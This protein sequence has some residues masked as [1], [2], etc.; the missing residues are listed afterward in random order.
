MNRPRSP[1][2]VDK[3]ALPLDTA[4]EKTRPTRGERRLPLKTK[5]RIRSPRVAAVLGRRIEGRPRAAAILAFAAFLHCSPVAAT[6]SDVTVAAGLNYEHGYQEPL[7]G[8]DG[9]FNE[10]RHTAGGVAAGDYDND[11]WIDLYAVR[12]DTGP[13]VLFRNQ[14]DGT[15]VEVGAAAGVAV[16]GT[17]GSGPIFAD[18]DG[19][20]WLD[21]LVGGVQ[22]AGVRGFR[23][24]GDGSFAGVDFG[25]SLPQPAPSSFRRGSGSGEEMPPG[26]RDTYSAAFGDYDRDGDLDMALAHWNVLVEQGES[27]ETL[28]R[29]DGD[30]HF[31]DVSVDS[32][33]AAILRGTAN[34]FFDFTFTPNFADVD[35]DGFPDLLLAADFGTSKVLRNQGD[36]TFADVTDTRVV[37]DENGMGAAIGD[38]DNDGDLDW[39][40][41]SIWDP[42][43]VAEEHWG[44]TGNRLYRN[45]GDGTFEDVTTAAGVRQGYWGWGATWADVNND[46]FL[47]LFHVNGWGRS[48]EYVP[49]R[50][51]YRDPSPLFV[52]A[53]DGTF[54][55]QAHDLGIDDT[56]MGRGVVSFDYDRDGDLDFFIANSQGRPRLWR[57]DGG[58]EQ[59][60]LTVKLRGPV[61]NS[62]GIG[63]RVE[64][65]T[66]D[67][68][69][70]RELRAGSNFESQD[71][72]EAHFGLGGYAVADAVRVI[73]PDGIETILTDVVAG[74]R[75]V[76]SI[77][78]PTPT[79]SPTLTPPTPACIGDCDGSGSVTVDELVRAVTMALTGAS[80]VSCPAVDRNRDG[81][82]A[83]DEVVAALDRVLTGCIKAERAP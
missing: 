57:N 27:T 11:G 62:E 14:G 1:E 44:V 46:G 20:G 63:A 6:F 60:Y 36:G 51:F 2:G 72:A 9:S 54:T 52:A 73:W 61:G 17:A 76:V 3:C 22:G 47:D 66:G 67:L 12:G 33:I 21:I 70:M 80:A 10:R 32:R 64:V 58:N 35:S 19:D 50:D 68:T 75:L 29:N 49:S 83:V 39:F 7:V 53:G 8:E 38:Y 4:A 13:D 24:R 40:V 18:I 45:R 34:T 48:A 25:M 79:T 28:W 71:P 42:D 82:V 56:G 30:F 77:P 59:T 81:S 5:H 37:T 41:S 78:E 15:F 55:E 16:S 31:T 69:Q 74:Q 23:G 26:G 65:V 43:G